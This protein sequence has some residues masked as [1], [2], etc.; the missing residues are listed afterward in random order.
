MNRIKKV[1]QYI[2][3]KKIRAKFH[4]YL[5][6][7][8]A[9]FILGDAVNCNCCNKNYSK[10]F[11]YGDYQKRKNAICPNCLS[12]ERTRLLWLFLKNSNYIKNISILQFSPFKII[13]KQLQVIAGVTYVSGDID[14]MLAMK[15]IDITNIDFKNSSFDVV[16]CSHV[17]SVVKEDLKA[18]KEL[19][20]VLKSGGTLILQEHIF[21][22]YDT[23]FEDFSISTDDERF[24]T[25]GK[26][27]LQRCYG[28]DF[29][30]R[31]L[32][33]GFTVEIFDP[34]K[35]LSNEIIQKHG[36]QNSGVIHLFHRK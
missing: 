24:K 13:E 21:K 18:I 34:V 17:L 8:K 30:Q 11:D 9:V 32:K 29:T 27:Y 7:L 4:I 25:Y 15:K 2:F 36:L 28:N 6:K 5:W 35:E 26:H 20:R 1:Y 3:S 23:T 10:F 33:E 12:L 22:N 31:F 14:P 16:I 19:Y